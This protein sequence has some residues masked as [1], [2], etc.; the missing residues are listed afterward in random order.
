M[1]EK[2]C[3][4]NNNN[5]NNSDLQPYSASAIIVLTQP[6]WLKWEI[7]QQTPVKPGPMLHLFTF[8][9]TKTIMLYWSPKNLAELSMSHSFP[10]SSIENENYTNKMK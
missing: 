10:S 8:T 7:Y 9:L 6:L 2:Y 3:I 4:D 5:N 1:T